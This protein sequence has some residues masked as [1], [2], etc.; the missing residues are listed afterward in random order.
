MSKATITDP[1]KLS[2]DAYYKAGIAKGRRLERRKF[3]RMI[4][5]DIKALESLGVSPNPLIDLQMDLHNDEAR[6][7]R[8]RRK[9]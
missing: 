2:A 8:G 9:E 1:M 4:A 6:S 5:H 7:K 3:K